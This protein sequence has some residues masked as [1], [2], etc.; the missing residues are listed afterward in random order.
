MTYLKVG[1]PTT[2]SQSCIITVKAVAST[3][4]DSEQDLINSFTQ[5]QGNLLPERSRKWL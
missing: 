1:L 2:R 3:K 5:E 4:I